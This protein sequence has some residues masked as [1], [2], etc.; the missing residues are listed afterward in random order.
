MM[1][2]GLIQKLRILLEDKSQ[3]FQASSFETSGLIAQIIDENIEHSATALIKIALQ[4]YDLGAKS[5][6]CGCHL[7]KF[8]ERG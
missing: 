6:L 8:T 1:K 3:A 2:Y 4:R 7:L 5:S